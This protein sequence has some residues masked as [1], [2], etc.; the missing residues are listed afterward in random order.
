MLGIFAFVLIGYMIVTLIRNALSSKQLDPLDTFEGTITLL[1][2]VSKLSPSLPEAWLEALKEFRQV[3]GKLTIKFLIDGLHPEQE[4]WSALAQR[5]PYV[6]AQLFPLRP[7]EMDPIPWMLHQAAQNV[8][9]DVV[10]IGDADLIPT[11]FAFASLAKFVTSSNLPHLV[12]PQTSRRSTLGEA[13]MALNPGL[14]LASITPFRKKGIKIAHPLTY[15][16]SYWLG[17]P[18][19][20]FKDLKFE[21][22]S[23]DAWKPEVL[24]ALEKNK[25]WPR[26]VF[27]EK[28]LKLDYPADIGELLQ[29]QER[30]WSESWHR[31]TDKTAFGLFVLVLLL[32]SIPII[33][34]FTS[35]LWAIASLMLLMGYRFFGK[36]VFQDSWTAYLLHPIGCG[37]QVYTLARFLISNWKQR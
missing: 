31:S 34:W 13:I 20:I 11:E 26:L 36:I 16:A 24:E 17:L 28:Q 33:F 29:C 2:P 10:I 25:K 18:L 23:S 21:S 22:I 5:L 12:L 6:E 30:F 7:S 19:T 3:P 27:G 8:E 14:A 9:S 35:P 1:V 4:N 32:W 15:L 37:V